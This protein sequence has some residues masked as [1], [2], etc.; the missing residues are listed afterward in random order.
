MIHGQV[1]GILFRANVEEMAQSLQITGWVRNNPNGTV[2]AVFE[3]EE[4]NLKKI[5]EF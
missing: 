5:L 3:G 4:N 2:E 1:Q